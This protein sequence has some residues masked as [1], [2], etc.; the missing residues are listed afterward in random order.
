MTRA[1]RVLLHLGLA[2]WVG[3][4]C[5]LGLVV[6]PRLFHTVPS[7]QAGDLFGEILRRFT[8]FELSCGGVALLGACLTFAGTRRGGWISWARIVLITAMLLITVGSSF[9]VHPR[10]RKLRQ[11][12]G[13][14]AR[15]KFE[16]LHNTST[17]LMQLN[18]LLGVGVLAFSAWSHP[19]D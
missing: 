7:E 16:S 5:A 13:A 3:G 17:R 9:G 18:I 6:A 19:R 8:Y 12:S 1:G 4:A 15:Q 14:E 10:V 2:L 11:E